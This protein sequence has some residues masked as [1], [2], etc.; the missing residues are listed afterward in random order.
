M[1]ELMQTGTGGDDVILAP[2][3]GSLGANQ[4][5][6]IE[7][8]APQLVIVSSDFDDKIETLKTYQTLLDGI[9]LAFDSA[10]PD[11]DPPGTGVDFLD[12]SKA[13]SKS[14]R[15]ISSTTRATGATDHSSG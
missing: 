13:M 3:H 8:A 6:F 12:I 7:W 2:H 9:E 15:G 5:A 11:S 14:T 10:N 1:Q 4:A